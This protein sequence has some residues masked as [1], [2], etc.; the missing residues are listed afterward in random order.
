MRIGNFIE[1]LR[2][3]VVIGEAQLAEAEFHGAPRKLD[4]PPGGMM[5]EWGVNVIIGQ[6]GIHQ[7]GQFAESCP[8]KHARTLRLPRI[9]GFANLAP[10]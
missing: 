5:T 4:R 2:H 3:G 7:S 9:I 8:A 10:A 6:S 1:I